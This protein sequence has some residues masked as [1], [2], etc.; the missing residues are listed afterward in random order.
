MPKNDKGDDFYTFAVCGGGAVGK[1]SVTIRWTQDTFIEI[2]DPTIEATFSIS[3]KIDNKMVYMQIIDTAGQD[4]FSALQDVYMR[5]A[6]GFVLVFDCTSKQ[7]LEELQKYVEKVQRV[8]MDEYKIVD[9]KSFPCIIIANKYDLLKEKK[10]HEKLEQEIRDLIKNNIDLPHNT[11]LFFASA[12]DNLNMKESLDAI[13]KE[14]RDFEKGQVDTKTNKHQRRNSKNTSGGLF[15]SSS[16]E[17][18][19]KDLERMRE[20]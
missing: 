2:Y 10:N 14:M 16:S 3:R 11:P 13:I 19:D 15:S 8:K 6:Y 20:L 17:D 9:G 5:T 12:K 18:K 7:S 4:E 1:S